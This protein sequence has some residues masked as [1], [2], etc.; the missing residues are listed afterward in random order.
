MLLRVAGGG[1]VVRGITKGGRLRV[2]LAGSERVRAELGIVPLGWLC[3]HLRTEFP[4]MHRYIRHGDRESPM[5]LPIV[6]TLA[7]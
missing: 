3:Y 1:R 6:Y 7:N 2:F 4:S 5:Q